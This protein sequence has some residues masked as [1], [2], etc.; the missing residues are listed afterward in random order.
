[1]EEDGT[2]YVNAARVP[3]IFR[4]NGRTLHHHICLE[5]TK[6]GV[7]VEEKLVSM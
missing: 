6:E 2:M 7:Q 4:Q 3:R 5:V 1:V